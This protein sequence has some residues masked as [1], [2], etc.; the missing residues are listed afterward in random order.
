MR[1]VLLVLLMVAAG[2]AEP[3]VPGWQIT[4]YYTA[5]ADLHHEPAVP[6]LGCPDLDCANGDDNLGSYPA[7]FVRA[8][9]DEGTGRI[10][11]DRY[12]NWSSDVGYWLDDAPRTSHGDRLRPRESAAADGLARGTRVRVVDCGRQDDGTPVPRQVCEQL[13]EPDWL[14][15]DEF[16]PGLG[17]ERHIDL[18]LGEESGVPFT[19]SPLYVTMEDAQLTVSPA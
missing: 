19:E 15:D 18:Y 8:V 10:T 14:I 4:V 6:V 1:R 16:T 3:P 9:Q 5:V 11:T 2:C 7:D 17:G 13:S 12:L